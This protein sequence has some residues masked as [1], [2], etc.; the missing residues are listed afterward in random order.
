MLD[1][2]ATV[3]PPGTSRPEELP[4][5]REW[6][7]SLEQPPRTVAGQRARVLVVEDEPLRTAV[8]AALRGDGYEVYAPDTALTIQQ[9]VEQFCPDLTVVGVGGESDAYSA[10]YL[11]RSVS[12]VPVITLTPADTVAECLASVDAGAD[13]YVVKPLSIVELLARVHA[14]LR[15]T[16]RLNSRVRQAADVII[17]DTARTVVRSGRTVVL[18]RREF[19]L[20]A[21]LTRHPSEVLSKVQ[22]LAQV[23][24]FDA[25]DVN[26]VEVHMSSL[27]RKMETHGPRLIHTVRG[28]GYVLRTDAN[29]GKGV[30]R[31]SCA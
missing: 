5:S 2:R 31:A 3:S 13:D 16:G 11:L 24:G 7:P 14:L 26:L 30:I 12:N 25:Y 28:V 23:W 9:A 10:L 8:E 4:R 18:T 27:R 22:L 20:L 29:A 21:A 6:T 17:D 15:R 1:H 19:D